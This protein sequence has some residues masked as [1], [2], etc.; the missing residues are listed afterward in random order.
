L[1]LENV[2]FLY[3]TNVGDHKNPCFISVNSGDNETKLKLK[4]VSIYY[5]KS[6]MAFIKITGYKINVLIEN[7]SIALSDSYGPI[8]D[9]DSKYVISNI[10]YIILIIYLN[11]NLFYFYLFIYLYLILLYLYIFILLQ[12]NININNTKIIECKSTTSNVGTLFFKNNVNI[13][14]DNSLFKDNASKYGGC[15]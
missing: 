14:I 3:N 10:T 5:G 4:N 2:N 6:N 13:T 1:I 8:I 11:I 12:S 9:F 15:L 7:S